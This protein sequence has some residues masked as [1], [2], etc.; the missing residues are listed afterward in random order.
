MLG[1]VLVDLFVRI[2]LGGQ[3]QG[4]VIASMNEKIKDKGWEKHGEGWVEKFRLL[5]LELVGASV[6]AR[7]GIERACWHW[8]QTGVEGLKEDERKAHLE[9]FGA[10]VS[11]VQ[12]LA[13]Y[14]DGETRKLIEDLGALDGLKGMDVADKGSDDDCLYGDI[15]TVER[16]CVRNLEEYL[17]GVL[18]GRDKDKWLKG[19][20]DLAT[21][22]FEVMENF[23]GLAE[24][25]TVDNREAE[26]LSLASRLN[27]MGVGAFL[28]VLWCTK[29]LFV[30]LDQR[31]S[32]I[33]GL[34]DGRDVLALTDGMN[35]A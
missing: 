15:W 18:K 13:A 25:M 14:C 3:D 23:K 8:E 10:L 19:T 1:T 26:L 34:I 30:D 12:A 22:V 4:A 6:I 21:G 31:Y 2:A 32:D 17:V 9:L 27:G 16:I 33:F 11:G 20:T 29:V 7:E 35:E 28:E 24:R 5:V